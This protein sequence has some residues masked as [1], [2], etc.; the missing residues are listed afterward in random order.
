MFREINTIGAKGND[1][2]IS[3][4]VVETKSL[5]ERVREQIQNIE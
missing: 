5:I 3:E 4:L 1:T 2:K